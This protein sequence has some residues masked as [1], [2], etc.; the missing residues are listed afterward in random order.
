M[1]KIIYLLF[2]LTLVY[3]ITSCSKAKPDAT[4]EAVWVKQP[5]L[6]G[7]GGVDMTPVSTGLQ[8]GVISSHPVYFTITP[9][10]YNEKFDDIFSDDNTPLDFNTFIRIQIEKGKS[11]ILLKNYGEDWYINNIQTYY[12]TRIMDYVSRYNPFDLISNKEISTEID[13]LVLKDMRDYVNSLSKKAEFPITIISV[14]IGKAKPNDQQLDE[15]NKTAMYIQQKRSMEQ[16]AIAEKARADAERNKAIADKT[17]MQEM[18]LA[19]NQ[20]IQLKWIDMISNKQGANI[21][22]LVGGNEQ[23]IW[24][25]RR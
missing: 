6:F 25:I 10:Q 23:P 12:R 8:W 13:K 22:V 24:N 20:Y 15:M 5:M 4:Q 19:P 7:H 9:V 11:P 17:Y 1:K 3:T 14:N 16:K 18:N 21:D 2:V